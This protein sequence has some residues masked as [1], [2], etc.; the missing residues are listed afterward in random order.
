MFRGSH[1]VFEIQGDNWLGGDD[2]DQM[3]VRRMVDWVKSEFPVDLTKFPGL[4]SRAKWEAEGAKKA[5]SHQQR[6]EIFCRST[7]LTSA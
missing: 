4:M 2:F 5:L 1:A 7:P 6:A 3:I